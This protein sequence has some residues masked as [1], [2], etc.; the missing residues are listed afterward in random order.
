MLFN[1]VWFNLRTATMYCIVHIPNHFDHK[2]AC[3]AYLVSIL[4]N[5]FKEPWTVA[6]TSGMIATHFN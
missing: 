5:K 2:I 6:G 1:F 4:D 3:V